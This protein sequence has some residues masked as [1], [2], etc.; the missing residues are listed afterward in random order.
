MAYPIK[1]K[2]SKIKQRRRRIACIVLCLLFLLILYCL[3]HARNYEKI[4]ERNEFHI[5]ENFNKELKWYTFEVKK[6]DKTWIFGLPHRYLQSKKLINQLILIEEENTS[7]I[8]IESAKLETYPQCLQN[9]KQIDYHLIDKSIQE[10]LGISELSLNTETQESYEKIDIKNLDENTYYIWNYKGFYKINQKQ[11]ENIS[12]FE[13]DIYDITQ[14]KQVEN[15]LIVPDYNSNYYFNKFYTIE[16]KKGTVR[17]WEFK[18]SLYFDGYYLGTYKN[19]LFYVDKKNKIEWEINPK[20]QK[21]RK[22]GSTSKEGKVY[23][24]GEWERVSLTKM[25]NETL[26]FQKEEAIEYIIDNGLW[27]KIN[28][29]DIKKKISNQDVKTIV[30]ASD[31]I[32][33]YIAGDSLYYYTEETGEVELMSYFEWN[34]NYKNMIFI[35]EIK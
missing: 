10:K 29:T 4:Y 33:Y 7:C 25:M 1:N 14:V 21:M 16:M 13:K 12:L 15:Y 22:V 9:G 24:N 19:S 8:I 30:R 3:F 31:K 20:K 17:T 2:K 23:L 11:K 34:F 27:S 32:V 28:G 18:E 6:E 5:K 26:Q 35:N